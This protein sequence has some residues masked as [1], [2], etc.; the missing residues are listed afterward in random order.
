MHTDMHTH[1]YVYNMC[2]HIDI[3]T[4]SHTFIDIHSHTLAYKSKN[5][6]V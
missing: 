3:H 5:R 2:T 1:T 4:N 6:Q